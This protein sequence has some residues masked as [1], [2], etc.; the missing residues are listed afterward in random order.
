[1]F[2]SRLNSNLR[3]DKAYTYGVGSFF[4]GLRGTG[5]YVC[6]TQVQTE[7][8]KESIFEIVKE[9]RD[10]TG[11]RA[12]AG[13]ELKASKDNLIKSFPQNFQTFSAIAG[14][15]DEMYS[16]DLSRDLWKDYVR[17]I[18]TVDEG[19][20][21][22]IAQKYIRPEALLIVVVGDRQKIES[23]IKELDLGPIHIVT[24]K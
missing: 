6:Y 21:L 5:P 19:T 14:Q 9:L 20:A 8:T 16:Y 4:M 7:F 15:M 12:L 10:I 11:D 2:T 13:R 1:M 18:E 22:Q 17:E 23:R 3:E 24:E